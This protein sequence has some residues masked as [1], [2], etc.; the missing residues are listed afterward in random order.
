MSSWILMS[1]PDLLLACFLF[2]DLIFSEGVL[3]RVHSGHH[4]TCAVLVDFSNT[5]LYKAA[6]SLQQIFY[7]LPVSSLV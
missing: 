1:R 3:S 6:S 7:V 4:L 2:C 5:Y